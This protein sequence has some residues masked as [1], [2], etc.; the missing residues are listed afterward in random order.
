MFKKRVLLELECE[1]LFHADY[2]EI[3]HGFHG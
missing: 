2:A 3:V 1:R